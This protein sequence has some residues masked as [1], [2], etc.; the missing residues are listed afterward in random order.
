[1]FANDFDEKR[2]NAVVPRKFRM[3]GGRE[4]NAL[5]DGD[6][7]TRGRSGPNPADNL[8]VGAQA[9]DP[10]GSDED[11]VKGLAREWREFNVGLERIDLATERIPSDRDVEAAECDLALNAI[12][13]PVSEHDHPGAGAISWHPRDEALTQRFQQIERDRQLVHR[14]R[15]AARNDQ[16]VDG[17]ELGRTPNQARFRTNGGQNSDVLAHVTLKREDTDPRAA[18]HRHSPFA[19]GQ[20]GDCTAATVKRTLVSVDAEGVLATPDA[21]IELAETPRSALPLLAVLARVGR[22][23]VRWRWLVVPVVALVFYAYRDALPTDLDAFEPYGRQILTGHLAGPYS[24]SNDQSGPLQLLA[25]ATAPPSMLRTVFRTSVLAAV[26]SIFIAL[27][28]LWLV[29]FARRA[30]GLLPSPGLETTAGL[31]TA[32]WVIGGEALGGHLAELTIPVSWVLAALAVRRGRWVVA[33]VLLGTSVGWESWGILGLPIA[34]LALDFRDAARATAVA[35]GTAAACYAPFLIAGPFRM[36]KFHW[37]VIS[38]T[39][40]HT[41]WPHTTAFGWLPR[42]LQGGL[43]LAIGSAIALGLRRERGVNAVWLVPVAILLMRFIFDPVQFSYY[44]VAAQVA[45][46]AGL[47][48]IDIRKRLPTVL[49]LLCFWV[50]SAVFGEW[51]T[52]DSVLA[53]ALV[54]AL[55]VIERRDTD[56][57][58]VTRPLPTAGGQPVVDGKVGD[59]DPNHRLAQSAGHLR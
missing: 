37:E 8:N 48:F 6:D 53:L 59:V 58:A 23:V 16:R 5:P 7:P 44:W 4:Q 52:I 51:K 24:H 57:A 38:G 2:V 3:E 26:W 22:V 11:R 35:L 32:V 17:V 19:S 27:G 14:G 42:S 55:A 31:L 45:L 10:R 54:V 28:S 50:T 30:A 15:L 43:C 33:G 40:V 47:A 34:L 41:L 46:V 49:L 12:D 9:F 25:A 29:R 1:V 39:L 18:H 36:L 13:H 56:P 21:H 20:H